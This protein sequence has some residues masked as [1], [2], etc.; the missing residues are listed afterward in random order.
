MVG[1]VANRPVVVDRG[2]L[3]VRGIGVRDGRDL[4]LRAGHVRVGQRPAEDTAHQDL[5]VRIGLEPLH[6][7]GQGLDALQR[8]AVGRHRG[9][10]APGTFVA[11]ARLAVVEGVVVR[12]TGWVP[13][14]RRRGGHLLPTAHV[15]PGGAAQAGGFAAQLGLLAE[16]AVHGRGRAVVFVAQEHEAEVGIAAQEVG[17]LLLIANALGGEREFVGL[18]LVLFAA[19]EG[20]EVAGQAREHGVDVAGVV[21]GIAA[22]VFQELGAGV[23]GA[24]GGL[25]QHLEA[26][27]VAVGADGAVGQGL[28]TAASGRIGVARAEIAVDD[29]D[30]Q[31][32]Q[33]AVVRI[34]ERLD[35]LRELRVHLGDLGGHG[36][37]VVHHEHQVEQTLRR[38]RD[39]DVGLLLG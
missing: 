21:D 39:V 37:R 14:T 9:V 26:A 4:V 6:L 2:V 28:G 33:G 38:D 1:V 7:R 11:H 22:L 20:A 16:H 29:R 34:L 35:Q 23:E 5:V 17:L 8:V 30:A 27:H 15:G 10:S 3:R 19:A 31:V 32:G 25:G 13:R 24:G 36:G 12:G 18:Q